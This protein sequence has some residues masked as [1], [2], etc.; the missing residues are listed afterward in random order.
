MSRHNYK[1]PL[2]FTSGIGDIFIHSP[3]PRPPTPPLG[4]GRTPLLGLFCACGGG[5]TEGLI[6]MGAL[7]WVS[8]EI[9]CDGQLSIL[10]GV[11]VFESVELRDEGKLVSA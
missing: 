5:Y 8:Y 9:D 3:Q 2:I 1:L 6:A 10:L 4:I 11:V 7:Y